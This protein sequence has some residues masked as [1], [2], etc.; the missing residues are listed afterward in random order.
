[1]GIGPTNGYWMKM[2]QDRNAFD[3][4]TSVIELGP[5]RFIWSEKP[6]LRF[7]DKHFPDKEMQ[8]RYLEKLILKDGVYNEDVARG[9]FE[10][11][12][13]E[14]YDSIEIGR[15]SCRERV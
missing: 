1:M 8:S 9:F 2:L 5:S 7:L 4:A 11:L 12:G 14:H 13:F 6:L 10:L 15:A 3:G